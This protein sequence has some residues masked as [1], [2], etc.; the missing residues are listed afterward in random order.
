MNFVMLRSVFHNSNEICKWLKA[1]MISMQ[2][3]QNE[4]HFNSVNRIGGKSTFKITKILTI[5]QG[6]GQVQ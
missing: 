6:N 2:G 4:I 3:S 5:W 1:E